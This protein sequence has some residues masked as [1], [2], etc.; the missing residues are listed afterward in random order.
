[1]RGRPRSCAGSTRTCGAGA[2]IRCGLCL[3]VCPTYQI[4]FAEEEGPRGRIAMARALTEGHLA[5]TADL[6]QHSQTC[7]LCDACT[8]ICPAGVRMEP[9]GTAIESEVFELE[10]PPYPPSEAGA[11]FSSS[12]SRLR[13]CAFSG[14]A[15]RLGRVLR[16]IRHA[17]ARTVERRLVTA[18]FGRFRGDA[19]LCFR[20]SHLSC[21]RGSGGCRRVRRCAR[22]EV[23]C[24]PAAS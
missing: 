22:V 13:T 6:E 2:C 8:A 1:M 9:L 11:L 14:S 17:A 7:L 16:A 23:D 20:G 4:S 5:L 18:A 19:A 21:R 10:L 24:S 3:S 12:G 15:C